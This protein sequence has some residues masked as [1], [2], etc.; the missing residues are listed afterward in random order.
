MNRRDF[1]IGAAAA[2]AFAVSPRRARGQADDDAKRARIA[3]MMFG[4]NSIVRNN[5]PEGPSRTLDIM[6][7]GQLAAETAFVEHGDHLDR[8]GHERG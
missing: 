2:A 8:R 4:L 3:I 1:V 6:D 7:I 5:M